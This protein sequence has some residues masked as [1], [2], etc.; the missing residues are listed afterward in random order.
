[1]TNSRWSNRRQARSRYPLTNR[2]WLTKN[3][4]AVAIARKISDSAMLVSLVPQEAVADEPDHVVDRVERAS[5]SRTAAGS[6]VARVEDAAEEDQRLQDERL[7]DADVVELL[8]AHADEH[9]ELREEE[10]DEEQPR[11]AARRCARPGTSTSTEA[12]QKVST[13]TITA[14]Q[15]AAEATARAAAPTARRARRAGRRSSAGTSAAESRTRCCENAFIAQAIMIRPGTMKTDV[16]DAV[17]LVDAA[18]PAR[19]PK[20]EM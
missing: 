1:M 2:R 6:S 19:A 12:A 10:A 17:E 5:A 11:A 18:S 14:A 7:V 20:T 4:A 3:S 16:V 15:E 9:A 13:A 8:G